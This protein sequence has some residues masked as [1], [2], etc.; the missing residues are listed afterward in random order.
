MTERIRPVIRFVFNKIC[1]LENCSSAAAYWSALP[2]SPARTRK[3]TC[4]FK[5]RYLERLAR[6]NLEGQAKARQPHSGEKKIG[7]LTPTLIVRKGASHSPFEA[8]DVVLYSVHCSVPWLYIVTTQGLGRTDGLFLFRGPDATVAWRAVPSLPFHYG[9]LKRNA[10][11]AAISLRA[12]TA[13]EQDPHFT[14]TL[15]HSFG[16]PLNSF[17]FVAIYPRHQYFLVFRYQW[18]FPLSQCLQADTSE[19][20]PRPRNPHH[21]MH[22]TPNVLPHLNV[23]SISILQTYFDYPTHDLRPHLQ[24]IAVEKAAVSFCGGPE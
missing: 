22:I 5:I 2:H 17:S 6:A 1:L 20:Q 18:L 10:S 16:I 19:P 7:N 23:N 14:P 21:T 24:A 11:H 15:L 9:N 3:E 4:K 8:L 13:Q 12:N